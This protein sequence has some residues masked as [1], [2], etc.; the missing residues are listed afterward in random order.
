MNEDKVASN[1]AP[2]TSAPTPAERREGKTHRNLATLLVVAL[3]A[4]GL[5][6][7]RV[8]HELT[9]LSETLHSI[10]EDVRSS[11][12]T[13]ALSESSKFTVVA[14][15]TIK[16]N[17]GLLTFI[18][19]CQGKIDALDDQALPF[20]VGENKLSFTKDDGKPLEVL[21][22]ASSSAAESP[23]LMD[24]QLLASGNVLVSYAADPCETADQ[25]GAGQPY[26]HVTAVVDAATGEHRALEN[27]PGRG[28]AHWNAIGTKAV[29]VP[30]TCTA[31]GCTA[32]LLHGYDLAKDTFAPVGTEA[33]AGVGTMETVGEGGV[34][35]EYVDADGNPLA[36]WSANPVEWKDNDSF[37]AHLTVQN[38]RNVEDKAVEL[39]F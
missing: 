10:S 37:T 18:H 7:W 22:S 38:G 28:W 39:S 17:A 16:T 26:N 33:D 35:P 6:L 14:Q 2:A 12:R 29:F 30:D 36:V 4:L 1:T 24:L 32:E 11:N 3:V 9:F 25:C 8:D 5:M 31:E 20:C 27:Y 13:K 15:R 34:R 19:S 21:K 23:V